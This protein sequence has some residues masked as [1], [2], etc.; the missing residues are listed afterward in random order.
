MLV[1]DVDEENMEAKVTWEWQTGVHAQIFGDADPLPTG[2]MVGTF[3]PATVHTSSADI[4]ESFE[5]SAVE[6]TRNGSI[7]WML[8]LTGTHE[9]QPDYDRFDGEAP[10]GWAFYSV[11]RF[12]TD[13]LFK[14][15]TAD[16]LSD[17]VSF[18]VYNTHRQQFDLSATANIT[19]DNGVSVS[20]S[21]TIA[22]HWQETKFDY[23]FAH[24]GSDTECEVTVTTE[25][26][27][28]ASTVISATSSSADVATGPSSDSGPSSSGPSSSS[29]E[30]NSVVGGTSGTGS[31]GVPGSG[32]APDSI[33]DS[34]DSAMPAGRR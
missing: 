4:R 7:A 16:S 5:A 6:V 2:N 8:G 20:E 15:A 27:D 18:S 11:E 31:A 24:I 1:M 33:A 21:I 30:P 17:K 26:G 14:D 12:Y 34:P 32:E 22:A 29:P 3:W 23:T 9:M 25:A 10:I 13:L 28:S 19:C